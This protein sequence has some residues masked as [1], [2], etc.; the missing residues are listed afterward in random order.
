MK[1]K[2]P[3][4]LSKLFKNRTDKEKRLILSVASLPVIA[5]G[6]SVIFV[7]AGGVD[8]VRKQQQQIRSEFPNN[9]AVWRHLEA[10]KH[11]PELQRKSNFII[12]GGLVLLI[13]GFGVNLTSA[14]KDELAKMNS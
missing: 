2:Q 5:L 1:E 3:S 11:L 13:A 8:N 6:A 9:P 7:G 4:S 10:E 14:P 12:V